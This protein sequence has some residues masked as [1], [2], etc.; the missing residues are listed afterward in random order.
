[1]RSVGFGG[2]GVVH[3][4][5]LGARVQR[6]RPLQL[7]TSSGTARAKAQP[8]CLSGFSFFMLQT[9]S[10]RCIADKYFFQSLDSLFMR[11]IMSFAS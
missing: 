3:G 6:A 10:V 2:L 9:T 5:C 8:F 1:M 11:L 7:G 4:M